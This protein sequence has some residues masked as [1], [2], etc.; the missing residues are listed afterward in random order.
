MKSFPDI[1]IL[2]PRP[3]ALHTVLLA[4]FQSKRL[5]FFPPPLPFFSISQCGE[6]LAIHVDHSHNDKSE[7]E[8][9]EALRWRCCLFHGA[10]VRETI[11]R[12]SRTLVLISANKEALSGAERRS[13]WHQHTDSAHLTESCSWAALSAVRECNWNLPLSF[14]FTSPSYKDLVPNVFSLKRRRKC[15]PFLPNSQ[16]DYLQISSLAL[17]N[18]SLLIA[19]AMLGKH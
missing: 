5:H 2:N 6:E 4:S 19:L 8:S 14:S 12:K 9:N 1:F 17:F 16:H 3:H 18:V 15:T 13:R 7:Q 11:H 10:V